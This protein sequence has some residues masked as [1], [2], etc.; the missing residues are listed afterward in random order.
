MSD[1]GAA[2]RSDEQRPHGERAR[3]ELLSRLS[4]L[5]P[6]IFR[7]VRV[8]KSPELGEQ[9]AGELGTVTVHQVEA[10]WA[11][12]RG[13]LTMSQLARALKVSESAATAL[14]E[15]LVRHSLVERR[16]DPRDRRIVMV[17]LS[18]RAHALSEQVAKHRLAAFGEVFGVLSDDRLHDVVTALEE[19]ADNL[20]EE[21]GP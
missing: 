17:E 11:L 18:E 20:P 16:S 8:A 1:R 19:V 4:E 6:E 15:R 13:P 2:G 14:V 9:I 7:H 10:L 3:F 12:E 5:W 21:Q